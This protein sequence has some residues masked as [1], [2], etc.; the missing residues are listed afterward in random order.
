MFKKVAGLFLGFCFE[1]DRVRVI[2]VV[3]GENSNSFGFKNSKETTKLRK[4]IDCNS[5]CVHC[6]IF[7]CLNSLLLL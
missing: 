6:C 1:G 7:Y 5:C 3:R 2:V 4:R